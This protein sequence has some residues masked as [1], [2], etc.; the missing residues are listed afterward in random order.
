METKKNTTNT[1]EN[2]EKNNISL[3]DY[4]A[5]SASKVLPVTISRGFEEPTEEDF[6]KWAKKCYKRADAMLKQRELNQ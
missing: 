6:D 5:N 1:K 4:F 3:R 2:I